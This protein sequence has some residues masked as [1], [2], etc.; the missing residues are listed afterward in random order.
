[1]FEQRLIPVG[2]RLIGL[3]PDVGVHLQQ[4]VLDAGFF[5]RLS[6]AEDILHRV[7]HGVWHDEEQAVRGVQSAL[8]TD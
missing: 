2:F 1:M 8:Q 5:G 6:S 4:D 3:A 7:L